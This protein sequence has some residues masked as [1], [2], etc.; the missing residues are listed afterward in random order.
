MSLGCMCGHSAS[1]RV[2]ALRV[3]ASRGR[4]SRNLSA[5]VWTTGVSDALA[6][7]IK[8]PMQGV[9]TQGSA[10]S[11]LQ[12]IRLELLGVESCLTYWQG[13]EARRARS[14]DA[15]ERVRTQS[16]TNGDGLSLTTLWRY[17]L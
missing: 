15:V 9:F 14:L 3:L 6:P 4:P 7:Q 1:R 16:S 13:L 10:W 5:S 2:L 8:T 12:S 17:P 11:G